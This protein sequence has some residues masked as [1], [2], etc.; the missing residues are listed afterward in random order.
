M[1]RVSIWVFVTA[2]LIGKD[3]LVAKSPDPPS[4]QNQ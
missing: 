1:H 2:W 4:S 3:A